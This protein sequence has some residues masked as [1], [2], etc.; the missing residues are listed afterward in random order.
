MTTQK[1]SFLQ[2]RAEFPSASSSHHP[3]TSAPSLRIEKVN[4][5]PGEM[6]KWAMMEVTA[7]NAV[8]NTCKT[9]KS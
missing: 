7:E 6:I 4:A 5:D 9:I 1:V 3:C 8:L 2:N